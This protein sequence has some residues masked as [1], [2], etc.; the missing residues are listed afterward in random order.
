VTDIQM[1]HWAEDV[2]MTFGSR[3]SDPIR[4]SDEPGTWVEIDIVASATRVWAIVTDIDLPSQFSDEFL[5]ASWINEGPALGAAFVGRN[6]HQS[7]GE[8]EATSYVDV[9]V[10][11]QSFGWATVDRDNPGSRWRFDLTPSETTTR[12]RFSLSIGPGPSGITFAIQSMPEKEPRILRRR[13]LEHHA[14]ME[15]TVQG[16]KVIAEGSK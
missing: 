5:G 13:I 16:I 3:P 15:R 4:L 11:G 14:N 12:L 10:V 8:W 6:R 1:D 2:P 9:F 7:I